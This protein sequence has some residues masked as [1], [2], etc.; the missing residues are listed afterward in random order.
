M[1]LYEVA[2]NVRPSN[3]NPEANLRNQLD[4]I[5]QQRRLS[6]VFQ[7]IVDIQLGAIIGYEG[8]IRGPA[9]S[10][11]HSPL[12]L[13]RVAHQCG[14]TSQLEVLCCYT[15]IEKF[16]M[17]QLP[18]RLFL[19]ISPAVLLEMAEDA[20]TLAAD[21]QSRG[22]GPERIVF[23]LT[24]HSTAQWRE[25]GL[26]V[27]E[28]R[29]AGFQLA[30]DD[31]GDG[32]S[33][34]RRWSDFKPEYVKVDM[35]FVQGIHDDGL[36][37][38]FLR[39]IRDIAQESGALVVAE[40]IERKEELQFLIDIGIRSGQ[41]FYIG[42]P[43]PTPLVE[44]PGELLP[45]S[46]RHKAADSS[47]T[48]PKNKTQVNAGTL[49]RTVPYASPSMTNDA[50]CDL[51][52]SH[53]DL[54]SI[55]VVSQGMPIGMIVRDDLIGRFAR[56]YQRELYGRRSCTLF[57]DAAPPIADQS[58]SLQKLSHMLIE[59]DRSR[60]I[61]DF[62]ITGSEGCYLGI[63]TSY[64]LLRELTE[65]QI[66]AARH[67]NPLTQLPGNVPVNLHIEQLLACE[68]QFSACYADLDNFKPFNDAFG[69]ARG[70]EIIQMT[71]SLLSSYAGAD[72]FV[73]HVGGDDFLVLWCSDDWE[74]R[75]HALL[76]EFASSVQHYLKENDLLKDSSES[77][78]FSYDRAGSPRHYAWPTLSLGIVKVQPSQYESYH[79]IA[80]AAAEAKAQAKKV[81]GNSI[82]IER[83]RRQAPNPGP[84]HATQIRPQLTA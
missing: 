37:Q 49:L 59:A 39:S 54:Q 8:L 73:G 30:L 14:L 48:P 1:S 20:G 18:G 11:L 24:E 13:F 77:G 69:Y 47:L 42:R 7:P 45:E 63:G 34:L 74:L 36:K 26:L 29:Q 60:L 17:L 32:Y 79:Q 21:F 81:S 5:L 68:A 57:M 23:E 70:D 44:L 27:E 65:V 66:M 50:V 40:G 4:A 78:Y 22:L 25:P 43:G 61:S 31:L 52:A 55:P 84:A 38:Q 15:L 71:G 83:R 2:G 28:Y 62:I 3:D 6:P 51:F 67:A 80:L 58:T 72:D 33:S 46:R 76:A 35:H 16:G 10:P 9:D 75:C 19:N 41:G 53:P 56:P 12:E 82:H 64:D